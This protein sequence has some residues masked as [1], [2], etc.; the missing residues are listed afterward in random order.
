[1]YELAVAVESACDDVSE[2]RLVPRVD[3]DS[4]D[5]DA[6]DAD[7]GDDGD[8][9]DDGDALSCSMLVLVLMLVVLAPPAFHVRL[10]VLSMRLCGGMVRRLCRNASAR[11]SR[12]PGSLC[13]SLSSAPA[14]SSRSSPASSWPASLC[15]RPVCAASGA[16][17][18]PQCAPESSVR[19]GAACAVGQRGAAVC[20]RTAGAGTGA[21]MSIGDGVVPASWP[22]RMPTITGVGGSA[23]S[24]PP[25]SAGLC[26]ASASAARRCRRW[27]RWCVSRCVAASSG[28]APAAVSAL[29][30]LS[31]NSLA[32]SLTRQRFVPSFSF[33]F[34]FQLLSFFALF[35]VCF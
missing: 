28:L 7:D 1:M 9:V 26:A 3:G 13:V 31:Q 15:A 19:G 33:S 8:D 24:A 21:T 4:S 5:D 34:F 20:T 12:H 27:W 2:K 23:G 29:M 6:D 10:G 22:A 35:V 11:S 25:A 32:R 18:P 16:V 14:P 30:G 17:R